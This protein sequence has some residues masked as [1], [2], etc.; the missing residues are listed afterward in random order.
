VDS[1]HQNA[2]GTEGR[3]LLEAVADAYLGFRWGGENT[4]L[5]KREWKLGYRNHRSHC[6]LDV[7]SFNP[8][9]T[10]FPGLLPNPFPGVFHVLRSGVRLSHAEA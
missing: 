5:E 2:F 1:D 3:V 9:S 4:L 10:Q 8:A 7:A 6:R